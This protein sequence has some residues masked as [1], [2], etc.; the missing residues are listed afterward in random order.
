[1][2]DFFPLTTT[3]SDPILA[4]CSANYIINLSDANTW[5]D[6]YLPGYNGSPNAGYGRASSRAPE[7]GL[8]AYLWTSKIGVLESTTPSIT[9]N[10]VRPGLAGLQSRN[11]GAGNS[12]SYLVAGAAYWANT[13]DIRPDL[14]GKQTIKT[15]SFDVAEQSI[16]VHDR[17]LY[18]MGKYGGFNNTVD[19]AV[20]GTQQN[21]FYST[22]TLNPNNPAVRSNSEWEDAP[23]SAYPANYLLA[24]DPQKLITG[25]RAAFARINAQSGTLSGAALTSANLTVGS[26]GAYVATFDPARWA[27]SI[28]YKSLS[29]VNGNLVVSPS[30]IWDAGALLTTRCGSVD[31]SA[32]TCTDTDVS[33]NRRNIVTT[34]RVGGVRVARDFTW[35]NVSTDS[36]YATALNTSPVNGMV[37]S[38]GQS[39]LNYLRGY[40]A[41]EVGGTTF[42]PRDSALGDII[43]S[44]PVYSG[45]PSTNISDADYA[46][47]YALYNNRT[48]AV[49]A[50]ANDGMLHAFNAADGKELFAYIPNF[51][52]RDLNDLTNPGYAH[53]SFVDAVPSVQEVKVNGAWKTVLV[54]GVGAGA[55]GVFALDVTNPAAFGPANVLFEFSDADDA[56]FGNVLSS[57]EI[58]KLQTGVSNGI[59][60]YG[61]FAVVTGYNNRRTTFNGQPDVS[62]SADTNNRGVLFVLSLDRT[63]G[64]PWVQGSNYYKY[65]FPASNPS[66]ANG[67]G[68]VTS[69]KRRDG[70]GAVAALYFGDL[71]GNLWRFNTIGN[72]PASWVPAR[73][74]VAAPLPLFVATTA[75]GNVRQPITAR[76]EVAP[77]P[78]GTTLVAFGTG[79]YIGAAD[80]STPY[81]QQSEYVLVDNGTGTLITRNT[82][83]QT[84]TATLSG[85]NV[86]V[87]GPAFVYS[88]ANSKKGWVLDFPGTNS[89]ERSVTKPAV[90]SGFLTFTTLTLSSDICGQ[91]GGFVYQLNALT[92]LPFANS[93]NG[94]TGGY[95]STVGIPGPP[96]VVDLVAV[97]GAVQGTGEQLT[98]VSTTT[99]VSGT[100]GNIAR[101]GDPAD[102]T[103]GIGV[104]YK[105]NRRVTWREITNYNDRH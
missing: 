93:P 35:L 64:T 9:A 90:Q 47:F 71:Q 18:L 4:T 75:V 16:D 82:D 15:I 40:R 70:T 20:D 104:V 37:D 50:G 24:S 94:N 44:G 59:P 22:D 11:T 63:L 99:L 89:G 52:S 102:A 79:E 67:L 78:Y 60:S 46:P 45:P 36:A 1:M 98:K 39:R 91:G 58:V 68:P 87:T 62:V 42:R 30:S 85:G 84:R 97:G 61:Y 31:V 49:F 66:L 105:P 12:A 27:G 88:G 34:L 10:D 86:A 29:V 14:D 8:D 55:Q 26:A 53:E 76:P 56:D 73:G 33:L 23:G 6:T 13:N 74:T 54:A 65:Y 80:L 57:P 43:N 101:S 17:Q 100:S 92:G 28:L 83:L 25:L 48:G 81:A 38:Q 19:R 32:T 77:G 103:T 2:K 69:Y 41:G 96:R 3:W 72:S 5:D 21:P 51:V 95:I 7:G